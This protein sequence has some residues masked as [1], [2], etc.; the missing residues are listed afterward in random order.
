M[1]RVAIALGSN[2]GDRRLTCD[3]AA[4]RLGHR[5]RRLVC[6]TWRESLPEGDPSQ[7][8]Y[9]NGVVVGEWAGSARAL[10]DW[11]MELETEAGRERPSAGA[12]RTLDL[13]LILCGALVIAEPGLT[14]P[15]PRFRDRGFVLEPLAEVAPDMIDPIT[16]AT[17]RDLWLAWRVR[18]GE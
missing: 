17:A 14:V 1:T 18:M 6:S 7:P 12:S 11:L 4:A 9:V 3:R 8:V 10:L 15:H 2:L 13:D 5:L 16:G